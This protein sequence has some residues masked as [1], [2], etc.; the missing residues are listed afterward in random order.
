MNTQ[1]QTKR[2]RS[3]VLPRLVQLTDEQY[4]QAKAMGNGNVSRGIREALAVAKAVREVE[5]KA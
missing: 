4:N 5:G 1:N 3:G 2:K